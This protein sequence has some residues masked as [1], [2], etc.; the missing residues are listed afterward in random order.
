M[1]GRLRLDATARFLQDIAADDAADAGLREA[2]WVVRRTV[3]EINGRPQVGDRIQLTTFCG[4]LGSRWAERRTS[5]V[6]PGSRIEAAAIWVFLDAEGRPAALPP[7]FHAAY[8]EAAGDRK[9]STR[10]VHPGKPEHSADEAPRVHKKW[11]L[12]GSDFDVLGHVNNSV[13]WAAVE[14]GFDG[15]LASDGSIELEY[16]TPIEPGSDVT[17]VR[18]DAHLWITSAAGVHAS[19]RVT[20]RLTGP[21]QPPS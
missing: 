19:A 14:D 20:A 4:G 5:V 12:R 16:R 15:Q 6:G 2:T 11:P 1:D 17:L 8:A 13:Y 3:L 10:L 21:P 18:G 9:V 7:L